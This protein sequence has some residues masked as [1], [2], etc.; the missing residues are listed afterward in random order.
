MYY[1]YEHIVVLFVLYGPIWP[2]IIYCLYEHVWIYYAK[3]DETKLSLS[4]SLSYIQ[5]RCIWETF[6][7]INMFVGHYEHDVTMLILTSKSA[8]SW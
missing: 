7:D 2:K 6:V 8:C 3:P 4:L 1:I 5:E